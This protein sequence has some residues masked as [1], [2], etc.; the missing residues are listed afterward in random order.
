MKLTIAIPLH[1]SLEWI[2]LVSANIELFPIDSKI[3]IS[4]RTLLDDS[5]KV[6]QE[7]H[8]NDKRITFISKKGKA[9]WIEHANFLMKKCKTKLFSLMPHDD[10]IT[11]GYYEK[12]I[13][14]HIENRNCGLSF[15]IIEAK[16]VPNKEK[17]I[18]F[19]SPNIALGRDISWKEAI[20]LEKKWNL[21]IAYRGV[22]KRKLLKPI[23]KTRDGIFAD[24]YWVFGIALKQNLIEVSDALYIK[25][26]HQKSAHANWGE[27]AYA[28]STEEK[29]EIMK[30]EVFRRYR[31][32]RKIKTEIIKSI[33][34]SL[35]N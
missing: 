23:I 28:L 4:D 33:E 8:K 6:L 29:F 14:A 21:G 1:K 34:E 26:Y 16:N 13:K 2:D 5:I 12:L 24:V 7:R 17:S 31:F 11:E 3:I 10:I 25:N 15:G 32:K 30:K 18:I 20:I 19:K 27:R 22:V 9:G 35:N